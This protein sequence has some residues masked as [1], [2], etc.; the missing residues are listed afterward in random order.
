[1]QIASGLLET[2]R[3]AGRWLDDLARDVRYGVRGLARDRGFTLSAI[4]VLG[5]GVGLNLSFFHVVTATLESRL[6]VADTDTLVRIVRQ[7]PERERW[8]FT[9]DALAF[10][11]AHH[12]LPPSSATNGNDS[13]TQRDAEDRAPVRSGITSSAPRRVSRGRCRPATIARVVPRRRPQRRYGS[14]ASAV[15]LD[16]R[17]D[18]TV[19]VNRVVV[20]VVL[21]RVH[22][23]AM[24]RGHLVL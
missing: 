20:A 13:A 9:M 18:R 8:A 22:R 6:P 17:A 14:D 21:P 16:H 4:L 11:P 24:S 23:R 15:T 1:M 19:N 12:L 2:V 10:Y 3:R 5:V 7:S